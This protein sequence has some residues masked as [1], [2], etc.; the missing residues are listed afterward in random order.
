MLASRFGKSDLKLT[1]GTFNCT[2]SWFDTQMPTANTVSEAGASFNAT[3]NIQA[4]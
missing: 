4:P 1:G 3:V 2:A